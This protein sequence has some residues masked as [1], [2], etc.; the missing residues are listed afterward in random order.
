MYKR[1]EDVLQRDLLL[2]S[3]RRDTCISESQGW[4]K[5][6]VNAEGFLQD[7]FSIVTT[8]EKN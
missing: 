4:L 1:L 2:S 8:E 5:L 6:T 7:K 3:E